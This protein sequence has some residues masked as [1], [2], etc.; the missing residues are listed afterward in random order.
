MK[1]LLIRPSARHVKGSSKPA[2]SLPVGLLYIAAVLEKNGY[3]VQ[4]YDAQL[5]VDTPFYY[6]SDG[7]MY[8]GDRWG[9]IEE[10]IRRQGPDLIGI[11]NLFTTQLDSAL[12]VAEIAKRVNKNIITVTG[13]S[14]P[15]VKPEDFFLK[16]DAVDIVGIGE[17]EFTMLE[18]AE[19]YRNRED[20][21]SIAGTAV[22]ENG[23]VKINSPRPYISNLDELPFPAYH[24]INLEDYFVLN[25]KGFVGRI[26]WRYPGSERAVSI[27]TSRGCPFNCIFCS[28]HLHMGYGWRFHSPEY[29]LKHLELLRSKYNVKHIH[30]EDDNLTLNIQRF[31]EIIDGLLQRKIKI[32]WDTTNGIRADMITKELLKKSRESGCVYIVVGV[33]SGDPRVLSEIINKQLD[34]TKVIEVAKWSKEIGLDTMAFFIIGFPGETVADMEKTVQFALKLMKDYEVWPTI[35]LATPLIGTALYNICL[36]KGY[37]R[38][39]LSSDNL[40]ISVGGGGEESLIKTED[41]GPEQISAVIKEFMR[42]YKI[43]FLRN[44]LLFMLKN[45]SAWPEFIKKVWF[46]K[47]EISLKSAI[48]KVASFKNCLIRRFYF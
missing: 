23:Q 44:F 17:G 9:A 39:E 10:E 18:I 19:R 14:H 4:I 13:G 37:L 41:F 20:L 48:L 34:L 35:F 43:I 29:V 2:V 31:K 1:I 8:V 47:H 45:P 36:K 11:S 3:Q 30:F 15:S 24:L 27:I 12:K 46:F 26:I 42:G 32:T 22:K 21:K 25:K 5:N 28:V 40:A 6:D 7:I 16:T 38:K 33:E